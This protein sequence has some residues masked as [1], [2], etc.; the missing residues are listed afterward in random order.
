M[1]KFNNKNILEITWFSRGGQGAKTSALLFGEVALASGYYI[2]A[3][4]EYGP[5]RAGAP[6]RVYNRLGSKF[7]RFR[8]PITNPDVVIVLDPTLL[9]TQV[10]GLFNLSATFL[11][12]SPTNSSKLKREQKIKSAVIT[13]DASKIAQEYL[14][15]SIPSIV[16]LGALS[17]LLDFN[18]DKILPELRSRL[19]E[20]FDKR[21]VEP[22]LDAIREAY[23]I[24]KKNK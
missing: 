17:G 13:I 23:K 16:M 14:N 3:F 21:L 24:I 12:N 8:T 19:L 6:M 18:L 5:E 9:K 7:I 1:I 2:Q 20:K 10:S 11:I 22:N 4:P 15:K